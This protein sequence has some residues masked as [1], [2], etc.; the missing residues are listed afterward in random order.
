MVGG[1][2]GAFIGSVH[3]MAALLDGHIELVCGAFSSD[4]EKSKVS[5]RDWYL[6]DNRI[7]D[8]YQEMFIKEKE[9]PLGERMDFVTIVTPNHLHYDPAKLALT[10]GFHVVCDKPLSFNTEEAEELAG[11]A[12]K[13]G[14]VFGLTHTYTGYPMVKQARKMIISGEFG[15]TRKVVVEYP[16]GWLSTAIELSGQKQASWRTDPKRSGKAGAMGDIGT[17]AGNMAEYIT[18]LKI[19]EVCADVS[20]F[21]ENRLLDDDINALLHF[22]KNVK[23]VMHCSQV[24]AG[25][26]N[27]I[28]IR[29][30]GETGGIEW[31]QHEPNSLIVKRHGKPD[32]N[33]RTGA[34]KSY[35]S[36]EAMAHTR[37]PGGHPEGYIE[38]FANIY[39]NIAMVIQARLEHRKPDKTYLDFPDVHDGVRGM[40]L[41]DAIIESG[42]SQKKWIQL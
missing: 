17:H 41:I 3:R 9:L 31:H 32:E 1:G 10:H 27:N 18:G 30:Y 12:D 33:Y 20:I 42:K 2:K 4:P 22:E 6:P 26:E 37:T 15:K 29:V 40:K 19:T 5:G 8:T 11:L 35:L 13:T 14:L 38:A 28:N 23:G 7:Y 36:E 21:I 16:Q 34:D 25:E 24:C 39:R